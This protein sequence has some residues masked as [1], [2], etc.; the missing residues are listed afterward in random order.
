MPNY[1]EEISNCAATLFS[2]ILYADLILIDWSC[3]QLHHSSP[4]DG[5][6]G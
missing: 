2:R 3:R 1:W 5:G 6:G 4:V